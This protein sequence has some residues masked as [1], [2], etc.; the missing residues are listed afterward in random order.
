MV[1]DAALKALNRIGQAGPGWSGSPGSDD[2]EGKNLP[3]RRDRAFLT[4]LVRGVLRQQGTLDWVIERA[5][6]RGIGRITPGLRNLLRLGAYQLLF[7]KVPAYAAVDETVRVATRIGGRKSG[8]FANAVLRA[9]ARDGPHVT[10][11]PRTTDLVGHLAIRYAHPRWLVARWLT[12]LGS[13]RTERLCRAN[14]AIPPLTVRVNTLK[15][16]REALLERLRAE[17]VKATP[18]RV[19]PG[20]LIIT[21]LPRPIASLSTYRAGWFYPQDEA[22]Q[23]VSLAVAPRPGQTILD[24]CAAP[25]GKATHLAELMQGKGEVLAVDVDRGRL[26]VLKEN[27][28]RLGSGIIAARVGNATRQCSWFMK[29][30]FDAAL[31]DAPCSGLGILRRH[32]EG[33]WQKDADL[34]ERMPRL[35]NALLDRL[36]SAEVLRPGGALIYSTCS[37]EPEENE[38]VVETFLARHPEFE[39]EDL[40]P[41]LP[42]AAAELITPGGFLSTMENTDGMDLFFAARLIR[43]NAHGGGGEAL[44]RP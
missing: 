25:G 41:Y 29:Q 6:G 38:G 9:V 19:A 30:S 23:L 17:G 13:D 3:D 18:T 11:P 34:I 1:R 39:A 4:E 2:D 33:K 31:V 28:A 26:S 40:R 5:S 20:G 16:P 42:A 27:A 37:T 36:A 10:P 7:T 32:P 22:A 24:A 35:Q 14:N 44:T 21:D 8:G 12:R 43:R 15:G